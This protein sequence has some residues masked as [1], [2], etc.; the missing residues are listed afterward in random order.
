MKSLVAT[1]VAIIGV[2]FAWTVEG[3]TEKPPLPRCEWIKAE[4]S[5]SG[6]RVAQ[7]EI[8]CVGSKQCPDGSTYACAYACG[9]MID[10]C[11]NKL[12]RRRFFHIAFNGPTE[13]SCITFILGTAW[14]AVPDC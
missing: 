10:S 4:P 5:A 2:C 13:T 1:A 9:D 11:S 7:L 3:A 12:F 14:C 8:C 6:V